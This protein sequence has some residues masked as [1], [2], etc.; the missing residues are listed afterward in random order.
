MKHLLPPPL[1]LYPI[2]VYIYVILVLRLYRVFVAEAIPVIKF[3]GRWRN[4]EDIV[5]AAEELQPERM[6]R[7]RVVTN[8]RPKTG[9]AQRNVAPVGRAEDE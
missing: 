6:T 3:Y 5:T 9:P 1:I 8:A 7:N 2:L 4:G